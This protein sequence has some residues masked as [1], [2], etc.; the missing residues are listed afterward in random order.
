METILVGNTLKPLQKDELIKFA[1]KHNSKTFY[2]QTFGMYI[3]CYDRKAAKEIAKK[4]EELK[5]YGKN[6]SKKR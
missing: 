3:E 4:L 5:N 1:Q 2:H 6:K